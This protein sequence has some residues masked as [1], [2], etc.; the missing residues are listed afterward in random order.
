MSNP[1]HP[2][3]LALGVAAIGASLSALPAL[4][5]AAT[6]S[7]PDTRAEKTIDS[8]ALAAEIRKSVNDAIQQAREAANEAMQ[9][10]REAAN[11]GMERAREASAR[12]RE[13]ANEASA[14]AREA[15]AQTREYVAQLDLYDLLAD[16]QAM[17]FVTHELGSGREVVKNAPYTADALTESV[18]VLG[19]GNR[20]VRKSSA[21][22]AR[23]GFGRTRQERKS[24]RGSSVYLYD[25]VQG[26][27]YALNTEQR[28]A[29]SISRSP[30]VPSETRSSPPG[31]PALPPPPVP[32]A[33]PMPPAPPA[34]GASAP[35]GVPQGAGEVD[36]Q[37]GRVV[38]R[39]QGESGEDVRVEVVRV[40][41]PEGARAPPN[42]APFTLPLMPRGTGQTKDL[43][44][45]DFEGIKATGTQTTH[46]IP[47]GSIGNEKPIAITTERWF[48]PELNV[49][50]YAKTSDPRVGE[51]TYKLANIKRGEPS[52]ELFRV[53][54]D[55]RVRNQASR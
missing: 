17:A 51:T 25:P 37:P 38:V 22:L 28:T 35:P 27:S 18:Q 2:L 13:A 19:D 39:R 44:T 16:D 11:E 21:F 55:Y 14:R 4:G 7:T 47:A 52:P 45:R 41:R 8:E 30:R 12:A 53:P 33:V 10:A 48:S 26:R 54:S 6:P 23:D 31:V 3:H 32:P 5:A 1:F 36:I 20:I 34:A 29:Y 15:A 49:V 43:G 9:R 24:G 40:E 46:T 50:V 42:Q